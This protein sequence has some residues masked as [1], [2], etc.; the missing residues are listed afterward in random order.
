[1]TL[2]APDRPRPTTRVSWLVRQL[3]D[4]P[5]NLRISASFPHTKTT[6]SALLREV[7]TDPAV[8]IAPIGRLPRSFTVTLSAQVGT[9]RKHGKRS[10]IDDVAAHVERFYGEIVQDLKAWTAAAPRLVESRSRSRSRN[11]RRR[12][13]AGAPRGGSR[14]NGIGAA[15]PDFRGFRSRAPATGSRAR[16]SRAN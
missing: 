12:R 3:R 6:T 14:G 7:R 9:H 15:H 8:L 2:D 1:M 16:L 5:P 4:A 10:F 11:R 13:R